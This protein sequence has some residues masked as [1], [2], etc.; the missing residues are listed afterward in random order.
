MQTEK[1][2]SHSQLSR[3][4]KS[5]LLDLQHEMARA[6]GYIE[7]D[8]TATKTKLS[9]FIRS[10]WAAYQKAK[11]A[12]SESDRRSEDTS[13]AAPPVSAAADFYEG[14][15]NLAIDTED[16]RLRSAASLVGS[17]CK[18]VVAGVAS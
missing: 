18:D 17:Y 9:N 15:L 1:C 6:C 10:H 5:E 16:S 4:R 13:I 14:L 12:Q 8:E 7:E 3:F 2:P 11:I